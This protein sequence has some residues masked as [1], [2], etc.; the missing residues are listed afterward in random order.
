M[1]INDRIRQFETMVA[2]GADPDN[3]M[4]W[5]SLAGAYA[6]ASRHADAADAY[7]RCTT[8][9]PNMSKAFQLAGKALIDAGNPA[10]AAE[11][12]T[13]G[14]LVASRRGDL[15][16]KKA[17][18][19][20]LRSI[21]APVPADPTPSSAPATPDGQGFTCKR[22]GKPGT[23]LPRPPMRGPLGEWIHQNIARE[24]WDAWIAQGTKV[25]NEMRLDLSRDE[26]AAVYDQHMFEYLG[27]DDDTRASLGL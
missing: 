14:Y 5:F 1:D 22:T 10:K 27:L 16:P 9:N 7:L 3:D 19:D 26:H 4:A 17:I 25:I 12:L 6:Q 20:L 21:N 11:T 8:L 24:T 15:M 23:R 13:Q 18:A 2:P